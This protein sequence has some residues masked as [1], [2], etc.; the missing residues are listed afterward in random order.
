MKTLALLIGLSFLSPN[1]TP[2]YI[3]NDF[4][5]TYTLQY[6]PKIKKVNTSNTKE[7]FTLT[8]EQVAKLP[9]LRPFQEIQFDR[10]GNFKTFFS[11][12][13]ASPYSELIIKKGKFQLSNDTLILH[14]KKMEYWEIP[15]QKPTRKPNEIQ[16][17]QRNRRKTRRLDESRYL[18]I[19]RK[20]S[21]ILNEYYCLVRKAE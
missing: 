3:T 18:Q 19:I 15:P 14:F 13:S 12:N 16:T 1:L 10:K 20:D 4:V 11:P 2:L 6:I 7:A 5:G 17:V 21:L 8:R 9:I